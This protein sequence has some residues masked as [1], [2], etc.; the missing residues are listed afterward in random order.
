MDLDDFSCLPGQQLSCYTCPGE[1]NPGPKHDDNMFVGR[2][3]PEINVFE[4]TVH[5]DLGT[6]SLSGQWVLFNAGYK[7]FNTTENF[8]VTDPTLTEQNLYT[9]GCVCL[10]FKSQI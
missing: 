6:I 8:V 7:W 10:I 1:E 9:G 2:L 4:A 5:N 3:A